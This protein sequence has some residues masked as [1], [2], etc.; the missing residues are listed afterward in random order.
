MK[1]RIIDTSIEQVDDKTLKVLPSEFDF[2]GE[3]DVNDLLSRVEASVYFQDEILRSKEHFLKLTKDKFISKVIDAE[4]MFQPDH[5]YRLFVLAFL[6]GGRNTEADVKIISKILDQLIEQHF[7]PAILARAEVVLNES[8][9]EGP[10]QL[11]IVVDLLKKASKLGDAQST[12]FLAKLHMGKIQLP[13]HLHY[14]GH[15]ALEAEESQLAID[16]NQAIKYLDLS[17]AQGLD[18][19]YL[20]AAYDLS[21]TDVNEAKW[22]SSDIQLM[23]TIMEKSY[24]KE[25]A[26]KQEQI[27]CKQMTDLNEGSYSSNPSLFWKEKSDI[28]HISPEKVAKARSFWLQKANEVKEQGAPVFHI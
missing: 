1:A 19:A 17:E 26:L 12:Y 23:M 22:Q 25:M 6:L 24:K 18:H 27:R 14:H 10:K 9:T 28:R 11:D 7:L 4:Q 21:K 3:E 13:T 15:L 16:M 2:D 20:E 8:F 5:H